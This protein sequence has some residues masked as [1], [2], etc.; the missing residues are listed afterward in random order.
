[1]MIS[2]LKYW[3]NWMTYLLLTSILIP[4]YLKIPFVA[5]KNDPLRGVPESRKS[6][7]KSNKGVWKCLNTSQYILFSRINDDWCDCEDGTSACSNGVFYCKNIGHIEKMIP[8]SYLN[9]G[10]CDCCDGSDEYYGIVK[11]DNTCEDENN[12]YNQEMLKKNYIYEKGSKIRQEWMEKNKGQLKELEKEIK[13]I[14]LEL[15]RE[16]RKDKELKKLNELE[17]LKKNRFKNITLINIF[18]EKINNLFEKYKDAFLYLKESHE[19]YISTLDDVLESLKNDFN[20]NSSDIGLDNVVETLKD[21]NGNMNF[22]KELYDQYLHEIEDKH[23]EFIQTIEQE[24]HSLLLK[25]LPIFDLIEQWVVEKLNKLKKYLMS[26]KILIDNQDID[27]QYIDE[28]SDESNSKIIKLREELREKQSMMNKMMENL[29]VYYAVKDEVL[30]Y[31]FK[32]YKYEFSF[33]KDAYQISLNDNYRV[34]LGSFLRFDGPN[35]LHYQNGDGCWNGPSRSVIVEL[36]CGIKNEIV[37]IIEY[38]RCTYF[39]KVLTPGACILPSY[40]MKKDELSFGSFGMLLFCPIF[41]NW[42]LTACTYYECSFLQVPWRL[43]ELEN[44]ER[45]KQLFQWIPKPTRITMIIYYGWVLFQGL[46]YTLIP[47]EMGYGQRTPA[48]H[49]LLYKVNGLRAYLIT[50]IIFFLLVFFGIFSA[51]FIADHWHGFFVAANIYGYALSLF[52]FI[53]AYLFPSHPDDCKFSGNL[54]YDFWMGIELNPRFGKLWDFKL[55]HNGR[56]GIICWTL[57]DISF[58]AAQRYITNSMYL[59]IFFHALYVMDFFY[60]ENWYLRTID[61]CHDH[62]GFYLAWGDTV[63]LPLMYTLQVQYLYRNPIDL[64][65]YYVVIIL[66]C[67][68]IG[69]VI[70]RGANNQKDHVRLTDG[71]CKIWGK[72]PKVIRA[73][74]VTSDGK[75]NVLLI[76]IGLARQFNYVGDLLLA[77]S[78]CA[79]CGFGKN[80]L[81]AYFYIIYMFILLNHRVYRTE[82]RCSTK[83]GHY[84]EEYC[85][86]VPYRLFPGI[87]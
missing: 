69:Y 76:L 34:F 62:F 3:K 54:W 59:V 18:K 24:Y 32:E 12:K 72:P 4:F 50:H 17:N 73:T 37:S 71:N 46:L 85:K 19:K 39:M 77:F 86:K 82:K 7:Y 75:I 84:W 43:F 29:N 67:G 22:E 25:K 41:T 14:K 61:I 63:W 47:S 13:N 66:I 15:A 20:Q 55:F 58:A 40:E 33:L 35:K 83:Y 26:Y 45:I 30:T 44:H 38:Q 74:Y 79:A 78:M 53:K 49:R 42:V 1:M 52:S 5:A 16:I 87:Y 10:I 60:H 36:H 48:G 11:C 80:R 9:D 70:F 64:H 57:I 28:I 65:P 68:L 27:L 51:S 6:L 23:K 21:M 8:S 56:P 81:L 2:K 31:K